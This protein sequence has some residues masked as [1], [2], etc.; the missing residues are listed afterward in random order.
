MVHMDKCSVCVRWTLF[1]FNALVWVSYTNADT[2][3]RATTDRSPRL[4][5]RLSATIRQLRVRIEVYTKCMMA[6]SQ[7]TWIKTL[8]ITNTN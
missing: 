7:T 2:L 5:Y 4:Y 6:A 8:T 1:S 3:Q